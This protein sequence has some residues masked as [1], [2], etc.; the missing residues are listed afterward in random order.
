MDPPKATEST[1]STPAHLFQPSRSIFT[2]NQSPCSCCPQASTYEQRLGKSNT[3]CYQSYLCSHPNCDRVRCKECTIYDGVGIECGKTILS[4]PAMEQIRL[5]NQ[6]MKRKIE[7]DENI[8]CLAQQ[9]AELLQWRRDSRRMALLTKKQQMKEVAKSVS[10]V[11]WEQEG[12][13]GEG[14]KAGE[15]ARHTSAVL[16]TSRTIRQAQKEKQA[17]C[18]LAANSLEEKDNLL[19]AEVKEMMEELEEYDDCWSEIFGFLRVF[20]KDC[21]GCWKEGQLDMG[22]VAKLFEGYALLEEDS[23]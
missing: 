8:Q 9:E 5:L 13:N 7:E 2:F 15:A 19:R 18:Y 21:E 20:K 23:G 11:W 12:Q 4:L 22:A 17:A 6:T 10:K 1:D 14:S 3:S 16:E